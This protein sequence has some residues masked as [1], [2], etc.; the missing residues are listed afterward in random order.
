MSK[1][2]NNPVNDKKSSKPIDAAY[3]EAGYTEGQVRTAIEGLKRFITMADEIAHA[4]KDAARADHVR[5]AARLAERA[6]D[7]CDGC[8]ME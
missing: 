8:G 6:V 1:K 2:T 5:Y 4:E 3:R 7:V